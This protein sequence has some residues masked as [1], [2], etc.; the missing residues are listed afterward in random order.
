MS[1]GGDPRYAKLFLGKRRYRREDLHAKLDLYE[2]GY[3][4]ERSAIEKD[5][6]PNID[7]KDIDGGEFLPV[8]EADKHL[9]HRLQSA[10]MADKVKHALRRAMTALRRIQRRQQPPVPIPLG[11]RNQTDAARL[12]FD[13][14]GGSRCWHEF[15]VG[16][17]FSYTITQREK[18][19]TW[20]IEFLNHGAHRQFFLNTC[21]LRIPLWFPN[22]KKEPL[23]PEPEIWTRPREVVSFGLQ[24]APRWPVLAHYPDLPS[25]VDFW[26]RP[27]DKWGRM[28]GK[29][30]VRWDVA[31]PSEVFGWC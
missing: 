16:H 15:P 19:E 8:T 6:F 28:P 18:P 22:E 1:P 21:R 31:L 4:A 30:S 20:T 23:K 3:G 25:P 2:Y 11:H 14:D 24:T 9:L 5:G 26:G 7:G 10:K 27:I 13:R 17:P 12:L 29:V